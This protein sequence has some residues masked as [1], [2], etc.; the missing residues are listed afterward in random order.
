MIP[1][2]AIQY[3]KDAV[4]CICGAAIRVVV[5][6]GCDPLDWSAIGGGGGN[7]SGPGDLEVA[8]DAEGNRI[9]IKAIIDD[10][11][12]CVFINPTTLEILCAGVDF[13]PCPPDDN[14]ELIACIKELKECICAPCP[15]DLDLSKWGINGN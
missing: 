6:D 11:G 13:F 2:A 4:G 14:A 8:C 15:E 12:N 9:F 5:M 10:D 7:S 3:I 1:Q